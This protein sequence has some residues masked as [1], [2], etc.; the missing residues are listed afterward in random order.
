MQTEISTEV[1]PRAQVEHT[2]TELIT[3]HNLVELGVRVAQGGSPTS[4]TGGDYLAGSQH[5]MPT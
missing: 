5:S 4:Q 2:V 1:N 3:G